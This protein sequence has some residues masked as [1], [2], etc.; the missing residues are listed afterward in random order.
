MRP[1][2]SPD[3]SYCRRNNLSSHSQ[4]T[5][6]LRPAGRVL[7]LCGVV[8]LPVIMLSG[9]TGKNDYIS[10]WAA[11][12][13]L[14][15]HQNP[16]DFQ[17]TFELERSAGWVRAGALMIRN[18]PLAFPLIA[19]LGFLD[20]RQGS[21]L[22]TLLV[23]GSLVWSVHILWDLHG[24]PPD[25]LH[26]ISY[27]FAPSLACLFAGQAVAV[28]LL[29]VVLFLK[30][31]A[32]RPFVAGLCL[33]MAITLKPHFFLAFGV[34]ILFQ[35]FR[36]KDFRV[37]WGAS[38]GAAAVAAL[39]ALLDSHGWSEYLAMLAAERLETRLLPNLS[40]LFRFAISPETIWL[41]FLPVATASLWAWWFAR[42]HRDDWDWLSHGSLLI[43]VS[44]LVAPYSWFF[45]EIIL[46]P[47]V[48]HGL[49]ALDRAGRSFVWFVLAAGAALMLVFTGAPITSFAFVWTP[50]AWLATYA[51][52]VHSDG[53]AQAVEAHS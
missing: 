26:L 23:M 46:L 50:V 21:I 36:T 12:Q 51:Y 22:W 45:D 28:V 3:C 37:I 40:G 4:L 32:S 13:L 27:V 52:A 33:S 35:A 1:A 2:W 16:Y 14:H 10:Y 30:W 6:L 15:H 44:V 41:Q 9:D 49:Y 11:A 7:L 17:S 25:R 38:L 43:L 29:G 8:A 19:P 34:V 48:L 47:A 20:A 53:F 42:R 18:P 39:A 24:R 5:R 31:Q